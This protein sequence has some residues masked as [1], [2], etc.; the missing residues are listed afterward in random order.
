MVEG[1]G[2]EILPAVFTRLPRVMLRI[3]INRFFISR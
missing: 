3:E 1:T 2:L